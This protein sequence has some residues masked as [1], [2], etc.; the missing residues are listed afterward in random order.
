MTITWTGRPQLW[1][2]ASAVYAAAMLL[3]VVTIVIGILN[4]LDLYSPDHDTL[5]T[6][7]HA[8]T[9]GW[10]TLSVGGTAL[11]V[12]G[13]DRVLDGAEVRRATTMAWSL[14]GAIA[15][16]VAAFLAGDR[17]PGDRI[18]RPIVGTLLFVV[19]IWFFG[20]LLRQNRETS[21][22][23]V[24]RLGVLLA[25]ISLLIGAVFG[26]VLGIYT[27]PMRSEIQ[28]RSTPRRATLLPD[29]SRFCRSSQTKNQMT[30]TKSSVPTMGRW[31]RS[32]GMRSPARNAAT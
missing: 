17:I 20:W 1:K 9:L 31:M 3:F 25:W 10:I 28:A 16:Y 11:L 2:A 19:V 4:G 22:S 29:V 12:F 27:A 23:S 14:I 7:V 13:G 32:P 6:H 15:L 5:M 8:G 30:T 21:G 26:V 18:Q 24:A